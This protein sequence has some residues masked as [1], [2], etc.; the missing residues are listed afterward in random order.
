MNISLFVFFSKTL[1]STRRMADLCE[2]AKDAGI[3]IIVSLD[4]QKEQLD[5]VQD[6]LTV[7]REDLIHAEK[8]LRGMNKCC[9]IFINPFKK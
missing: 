6:S 1:M 2:Q 5:R 9:G 7:M 8:N 3:K 4:D